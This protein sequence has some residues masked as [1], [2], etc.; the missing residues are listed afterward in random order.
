KGLLHGLLSFTQ[1]YGLYLSFSFFTKL[2]PNTPNRKVIIKPTTIAT[3]PQ[4]NALA[5]VFDVSSTDCLV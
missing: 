1:L 2:T 4:I 5:V 3:N